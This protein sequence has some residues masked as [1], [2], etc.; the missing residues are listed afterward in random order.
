MN[1][2]IGYEKDK[3]CYYIDEKSGKRKS[4]ATDESKKKKNMSVEVSEIR[5][6]FQGQSTRS[7]HWFKLDYDYIEDTFMTREPK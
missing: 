6:L 3:D 1:Y 7:Q 5:Y 2:Q 4:E